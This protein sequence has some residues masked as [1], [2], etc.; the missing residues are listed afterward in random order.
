MN[1]SDR[2]RIISQDFADIIVE[3]LQPI[4]QLSSYNNETINYIN[5][6]YAVINYLRTEAAPKVI[7]KVPYAAIPKVYGL[8][9]T[10]ALNEMGVTRVQNVPN[11]PLYGNGV[12]LGFV[13]TG[14]EYTNP[15]FK[16]ADNTT[17]IISIWDQTIENLQA[18]PDIF[19]YGTEYRREQINLALQNENPLSVVPST[20]ENG[21]GTMLA[22]L[23]GGSA[24]KNNDFIG[25]VPQ[26]EFVVVKLKTS[27][28]YLRDY[29]GIPTDAICYSENDIMFGIQYLYNTAK[30][31][32][33]PIAICFGLGTNLGNHSSYGLLNNL[34][35]DFSNTVGIAFVI[36]AGNEGNLSHHYYGEIDKS[37]GF[38]SVEL[39]IGKNDK[40]FSMELWGNIPGLYSIDITSPSGEYISR[41]PARINEHHE[42]TFLFEVTTVDVNYNIV[43]KLSGDQLIFLRFR[44]AAPGIWKFHVY[45]GAVSTGFHIWLPMRNFI[46]EDTFFF[47]PNIYTTV[48][49]PGNAFYPITVTAYNYFSNSIYINASRGYSQSNTIKPDIAAPG[50]NV[51]SPQLGDTYGNQSGSSVAAA[52]TTGVAAMLLEW[53]ILNGNDRG[54]NTVSIKKYFI[55]GANR[56]TESI[57]PNKEWGFGKLNIYGTFINISGEKL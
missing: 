53:G 20:D 50:V 52:L 56:N 7:E 39:M 4:E 24:D 18:I 57:Y 49:N 6:K 17:R 45:A 30:K 33:K 25:V 27:K 9:D 47:K 54:I 5:D 46:S 12:L 34:I 55:R 31:L 21:H 15:I 51:Y 13:D 11:L 10:S 43:D 19:Y 32:N 37:I 1:Q 38:D 44:D 16:N 28:N 3:Y 40:F 22:G 23:S 29:Y 36:G 41:I 35:T 14:I 26:A 48:T 2:E 42:I 8:I